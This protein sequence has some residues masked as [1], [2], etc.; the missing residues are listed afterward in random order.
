MSDTVQCAARYM[1][2]RAKPLDT[3]HQGGV[4]AGLVPDN[5]V[6]NGEDLDAVIDREMATAP[7]PHNAKGQMDDFDA[8]C[9]RDPGVSDTSAATEAFERTCGPVSAPPDLLEF[10]RMHPVR[11]TSKALG[12]SRGTVYNVAGGHYW[13]D[14]SRKIMDAWDQYKGRNLKRKT[15]WFI[16]RVSD[17]GV[18]HGGKLYQSPKLAGRYGELLAVARVADDGG[19]LAQSLEL[20]AERFVLSVLQG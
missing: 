2:L 1:H 14:D 17:S 16:R 13:P 7:L 8:H 19:L 9:S 18:K 12:L 20:P 5:M 4:F 10:L 15:S 11:Y 6:L 3:I